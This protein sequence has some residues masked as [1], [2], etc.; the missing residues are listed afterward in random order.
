MR[1]SKEGDEREREECRE[2]GGARDGEV[3]GGGDVQINYLL[4]FLNFVLISCQFCLLKYLQKTLSKGVCY[5]FAM[6]I[7]LLK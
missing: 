1:G 6:Y 4:H 3:W 7:I 2:E 5:V